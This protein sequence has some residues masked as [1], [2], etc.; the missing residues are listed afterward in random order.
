MKPGDLVFVVDHRQ[1][2]EE[3]VRPGVII[4][5][6]PDNAE[7]HTHYDVLYNGSVQSIAEYWLFKSREKAI[8]EAEIPF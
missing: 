8:S 5:E 1:P 4:R 7:L 3:A 6:S 2:L